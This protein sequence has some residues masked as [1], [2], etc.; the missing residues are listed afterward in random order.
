VENVVKQLKVI[1]LQYKLNLK[2]LELVRCDNSR[3]VWRPNMEIFDAIVADPPYGVRAGAK[4][5]GSKKDVP[6][7]V[8]ED[9]KYNHFP[10]SIP[11]KMPEILKDL[12]LLAAQH[13]CVGGRLVFWIPTIHSEFRNEHIPKHACFQLIANSEQRFSEEF[14]RRLITMEKLISIKDVPEDM[15]NV[16]TTMDGGTL[17]PV[18]SD[19]GERRFAPN[20]E[21]KANKFKILI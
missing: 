10:A 14:G 20:P 4:K 18:F 11:Y 3:F 9:R 15:R 13:L 1:F 6:I 17:E 7:S 19:Y 8:P 21:K 16:V 2:L 12:L 5:L